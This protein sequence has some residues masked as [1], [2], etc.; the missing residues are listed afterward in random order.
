MQLL[1]YSQPSMNEAEVEAVR[2]VLLSGWLTGGPAVAAFEKAMAAY[3]GAA[4]A[5]A[6]SSGTAALHAA[7]FA[8]GIGT[9]DEVIVPA[10]TFVATANAA[11]YLGARPV[12]ADVDPET[13]CIDPSAAEALVTDRTRAIVG[14]DYAGQPCDWDALNEIATR[15]G[16]HLVADA[17]H[18]LGGEYDT[19]KVGTLATL[20]AFSL[21]PVKPITAGEGGVVTTD[22][23]ALAERMR[24]FRNH[25]LN[26][27]YAQRE[28]FGSWY[29]EMTDLGFN[30]RMSD[31]HCAIGLTQLNKLPDW[32]KRR[33]ELAARYDAAFAGMNSVAPLVLRKGRKHA[34]HLYVVQ[35]DLE[36][37]GRDRQWLFEAYRREG[38]NV[39]VHYIPLNYHPYYRE[40]LGV[41]PGQCPVAERA[42]DRILSLPLFPDMTDSDVDRVVSV[43]HGHL[44][45]TA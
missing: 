4:E 43:S 44:G 10:L 12:I 30:Y 7:L 21:H 23:A 20:N 32:V 22:D 15:K 40:K 34:Y 3:T 42:Y 28:K 45:G 25:G 2:E 24:R 38:I 29:Y 9:G 41:G 17:C 35:F 1:P 14:M 19:R 33:G 36:A 37:I 6:V 26:V 16:L 13:L 31:I 18:A 8:L 5:V 27:E 39:Q 11:L